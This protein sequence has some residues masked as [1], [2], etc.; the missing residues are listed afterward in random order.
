MTNILHKFQCKTQL[1]KKQTY[2]QDSLHLI[3]EGV[4]SEKPDKPTSLARLS[5]LDFSQ[6]ESYS[7]SLS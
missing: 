4:G 3:M 1:Q 2:I 6:A 7:I 5:P